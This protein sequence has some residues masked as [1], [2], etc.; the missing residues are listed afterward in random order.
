MVF[1]LSIDIL[2]TCSL[3]SKGFRFDPHKEKISQ[4]HETVNLNHG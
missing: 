1:L 2:H 3:W 4:W